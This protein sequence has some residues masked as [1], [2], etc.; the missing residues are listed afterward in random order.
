MKDEKQQV[1][2]GSSEHQAQWCSSVCVGRSGM[3]I[4]EQKLCQS[5]GGKIGMQQVDGDQATLV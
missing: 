3:A 1:E 4:L 5:V 2:L